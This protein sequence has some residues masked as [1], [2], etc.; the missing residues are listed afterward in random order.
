MLRALIADDEELAR[1]RLRALLEEQAVEVVGCAANGAQA[2]SMAAALAPD[3]VFMDIRM[4][5]LDGL[6][7]AAQLAALKPSPQLVFCTAYDAHALAAFDLRA[8]DYL[9]K[10]IRRERL[11]E[12][13]ARLNLTPGSTRKAARTQLSA[14][15][16]G[17]MKLIQVREVLYFQTDEKYVLAQGLHTSLLLE[18]SLK[19]LEDEFA[20]RFV[21]IHRAVLVAP[22]AVAALK[23]TSDGEVVVTIRGMNVELEVSRR[24]LSQVRARLKS[25]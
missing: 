16:G 6:A 20:E 11:A 2:L 18:E 23:R 25:T 21:R 14:K 9:V 7:A 13:L 24:N 4:P 1:L 3:V 19:S 12:A 22:D 17:V 8:V 15:I 5:V 10:P